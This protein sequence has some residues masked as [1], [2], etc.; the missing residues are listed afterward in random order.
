MWENYSGRLIKAGLGV[1]DYDTA[2]VRLTGDFRQ[3]LAA[4]A[5]AL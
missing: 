3:A 5:D 2:A 4:F 1:R